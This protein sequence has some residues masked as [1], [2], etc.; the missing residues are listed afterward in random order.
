MPA[1]ALAQA[2]RR[3]AARASPPDIQRCVRVLSDSDMQDLNKAMHHITSLPLSKADRAEFIEVANSVFESVMERIEP[4]NPELTR[5]LWNATD[6][7]DNMLGQDMLP[8]SKDYAMSLIDAFLVHHVIGL[9][10]EADKQA[11]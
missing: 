9:A 5:E 8:I 11:A 2:R 7:V 4:N 1:T 3:S 10:T 6:Y